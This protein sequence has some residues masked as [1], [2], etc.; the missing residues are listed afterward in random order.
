MLT[1]WFYFKAHESPL[2]I[3][4]FWFICYVLLLNSSQKQDFTK[5]YTDLSYS[6]WWCSI[7]YE[8]FLSSRSVSHLFT[9]LNH[10]LY[11]DYE[12]PTISK[13]WLAFEN[14]DMY[15]STK[16]INEINH[17]QEHSVPEGSRDFLDTGDSHR[18]QHKRQMQALR[19]QYQTLE[20][21]Y[22][23]VARNFQKL[24]STETGA[25]TPEVLL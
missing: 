3:S 1:K 6:N 14:C 12:V 17:H 24:R 20:N 19:T 15:H 16:K 13:V 23:L 5:N 9:N 2:C 10:P 4:N 18:H 25:A 8:G 22:F 21:W 11:D 7:T